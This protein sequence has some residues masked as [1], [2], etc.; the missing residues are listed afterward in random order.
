MSKR[1]TMALDRDDEYRLTAF[2]LGEMDDDDAPG[3]AAVE[4]LLAGSPEARRLVEEIRAAGVVLSQALRDEP[5]VSPGGRELCLGPAQREAIEACLTPSRTEPLRFAAAPA[6]AASPRWSIFARSRLARVAL[7]ASLLV[8]VGTALLTYQQ[9]E[10]SRIAAIAPTARVGRMMT[11]DAAVVPEPE[12]AMERATGEIEVAAAP[13]RDKKDQSLGAELKSEGTVIADGTVFGSAGRPAVSMGLEAA[14][15]ESIASRADD[16]ASKP[17]ARKAQAPKDG[18]LGAGAVEPSAPDSPPVAS[19]LAPTAPAPA[20]PRYEMFARGGLEGGAG[21]ARENRP[22]PLAA[23]PAAMAPAPMSAPAPAPAPASARAMEV[24]Q[25]IPRAEGRTLRF[26]NEVGKGEADA[27]PETRPGRGVD[28][29]ALGVEKAKDRGLAVVYGFQSTSEQLAQ[30]IT[31]L[32]LPL[33]RPGRPLD[34]LREDLVVQN[35]MPARGLVEVNALINDEALPALAAIE[36]P[37]REKRL[38]EKAEEGPVTL[39]AEIASAPWEPSNRLAR[40]ALQARPGA[41]GQVVARDARLRVEFEPRVVAAFRP[42]GSSLTNEVA[43]AGQPP[44]ATTFNLTAGESLTALYEMVPV[45]PKPDDDPALPALRVRLGY[46]AVPGDDGDGAAAPRTI[47]LDVRDDG[48]SID[49]AS[50]S[51]RLAAAV[52]AFGR[53]LDDPAIRT[54]SFNFILDLARGGL[55]RGQAVPPGRRTVIE[56]IERARDI[57]RDEPT[58]LPGP[59]P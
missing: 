34:V 26:R 40:I 3:R 20:R 57:E 2:A 1:T 12:S 25:G 45:V 36:Q 6:A 13:A 51:F 38:E 42:V 31:P 10:R 28:A 54:P 47:R 16:D 17:L 7:A 27:K 39:A 4:A 50:E 49:R 53:R 46:E 41:P 33:P 35:R 5:Y 22:A 21:V 32:P 23:A 52:A 18:R 14:G 37:G 44:A 59:P 19:D 48:R 24:V 11:T 58:A 43:K 55:D 56:L 9:V 29:A 8:G 15:R 30:T